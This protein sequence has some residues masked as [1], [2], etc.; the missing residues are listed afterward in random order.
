M[1]DITQVMKGRVPG[2]LGQ[3]ICFRSAVL[4]PLVEYQGTTCL[5]F[6][7]RSP[8]LDHQPGEIC[9]PGGKIDE[10]DGNAMEAAVREAVE[11]LGIVPQEIEVIG[12]LDTLVTPFNAI[13]Y[14]FVARLSSCESICV[15]P[16]EVASFF[17]VPLEYLVTCE[18]RRA[19]LE[20][21]L[22]PPEDYPYE[23]IPFGRNYPWRSGWYPQYFYIWQEKVIWG[24]TARILHHFID[25]IR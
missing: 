20:V 25:L 7:E 22:E 16:S 13:I 17:C 6:E 11:E 15:N 18:P 23:L 8:D 14:P 12:E 2:I 19:F 24:L 10:K 9:F 3:E 21:K 4:L 1:K 5:L